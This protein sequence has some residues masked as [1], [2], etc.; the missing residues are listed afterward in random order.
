MTNALASLVLVLAVMPRMDWRQLWSRSIVVFAVIV[1][2]RSVTNIY[3][4]RFT[5]AIYVQLINLMTPF[6]VAGLSNLLLREPLPRNTG[7][8]IALSIVGSVLMGTA[9]LGR[10]GVTLAITP[11]DWVGIGLAL[12]S[13]LFLALYVIAIRRASKN[14]I[15]G[16]TLV[17][18]Q[19]GVLTLSMGTGSVL[20]RED[21]TA[22]SRLNTVGWLC[23]VA[24][25]IGVV[26]VGTVLQN[27]A[28]RQLK[29]SFY[30]T[31]QAWRLV[32]T[33]GLAALL[34]GE[35]FTSIWQVI[36]ALGVMATITWYSR[37]QN[38]PAVSI[39]E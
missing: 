27:V 2:L 17:V 5:L 23:F 33:A 34:L 36:G 25:A 13:S 14:N 38:A 32:S 6:I 39:K 3:A 37:L 22:W 9:D 21:W 31:L 4:A 35:W 20:L 24:F 7:R 15:S 28:L 26:L 12:T 29:A 11:G 10:H 16:Q 30:T 19:A 1:V 8:A 18:V